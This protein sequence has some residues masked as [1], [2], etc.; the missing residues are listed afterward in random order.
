MDGERGIAPRVM[1][2][3]DARRMR[4]HYAEAQRTA[5]V[6]L[7]TTGQAKIREAADRSG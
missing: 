3:A 6:E 7:V 2:G 4:K 5:L 1:R